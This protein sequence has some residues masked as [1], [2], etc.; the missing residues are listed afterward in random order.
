MRYEVV[1][2]RI[3]SCFVSISHTK[4]DLKLCLIE[5]FCFWCESGDFYAVSSNFIVVVLSKIVF[6]CFKHK[7][8]V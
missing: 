3:K 2:G 7:L 6:I 1:S 4:K 5:N 8:E